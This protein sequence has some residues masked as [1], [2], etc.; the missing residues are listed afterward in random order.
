MRRGGRGRGPATG[1]GRR[2]SRRA[3]RHRRRRGS[4][5]ACGLLGHDG[6]AGRPSVVRLGPVDPGGGR[7]LRR[8]WWPG[9]EPLGVG[10]VGGGQHVGA[11]RLDGLRAAVVHIGGSVQAQRRMPVVVVVPGEEDLA[12]GPGVLDRAELAGE[13]GP[14]LEG[15]ELRFGERV[16]VGDVRAGMRLGDAQ[17]SEQER[18]RLGGHRGAARRLDYKCTSFTFLG[19][20]FRVRK[21]PTRDGKSMFAAFLPAI[22]GDAL[23]DKGRIIR[24]WRINLRTT[25]DLAEL[26]E[27]L[28]PVIRG[29]MNYYGKFYRTEM[30]ALLRRIN[31]YIVR[32][33]R[34]KFRRLRAFKRAKR[35]WNGLLQRE[36]QL[37]VHWA[38]MPEF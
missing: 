4:R 7:Q 10:G 17:V 20:T 6:G 1:R 37:F 13:G 32:W 38:W 14:V 33:A 2:A 23:K 22:S 29:W 35:W 24:G 28:N 11:G 27:W 30:F 36:P 12:V 8:G 5:W 15:L 3:R 9:G 16:V 18:H 19:Y 31:T 34:R 26:A 25:S 21:A